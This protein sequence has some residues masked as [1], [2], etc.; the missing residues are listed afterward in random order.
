MALRNRA[1]GD[2]AT[3]ESAPAPAPKQPAESSIIVKALAW[4]VH[5]YTGLGLLI[6]MYSIKVALFGEKPD[7]AL[8]ARLNWLAI[9]VDATDGTFAR[10]MEV[11]NNAPGLDGALLDNI[12][13]YQTFSLLPAL[14]VFVFEEV[15]DKSLQHAIACA[16]VIASGYQFCQTSAKTPNAFVGFPSYWNI[17]LFYVH[18]LR[19]SVPVTCALFFG[20]AVLS[21]IPIHFI[22]PTKEKRLFWPTMGGAYVW[23]CL[24]VVPSMFPEWE[25]AKLCMQVSLMYVVYYFGASLYLDSLR[26]KKEKEDAEKKKEA[27]K[28]KDTTA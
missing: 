9:F 1:N 10:K 26:R 5:L 6:N 18:Y 2:V 13:D 15:P 27:K 11:W 14:A 22:Y 19:P 25:Y 16:I 12:I 7:F 3:T 28:K 23:G 4:C 20:C 17:L 24:M 8:F 21:F